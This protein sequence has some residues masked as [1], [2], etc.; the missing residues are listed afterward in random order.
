MKFFN[1]FDSRIV[2]R[3]ILVLIITSYFAVLIL[4]LL[5]EVFLGINPFTV[6]GLFGWLLI[7]EAVVVS[8]YVFIKHLSDEEFQFDRKNLLMIFIII[9]LLIGITTFLTVVTIGLGVGG[10]GPTS[11]DLIITNSDQTPHNVGIQ[12]MDNYGRTIFNRTYHLNESEEFKGHVKL[13][14]RSNHKLT[15]TVDT[16]KETSVIRGSTARV[17]IGIVREQG[18]IEIYIV[19][20]VP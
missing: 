8:A 14:S 12:I 19:Q 7:V 1:K 11:F 15:T 3:E 5:I 6:F 2:F 4:P 13:Q 18:E 17:D 16:V 20:A 10:H 9:V